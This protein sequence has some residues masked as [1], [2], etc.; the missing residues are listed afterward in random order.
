[1]LPTDPKILGVALVGGMIPSLIWLFFWLGEESTHPEPK[2]AITTIFILGMISVLVVLPIQRTIQ[3]LVANNNLELVLW[4][5]AEELIKFLAVVLILVKADTIDEPTD[6]PIY[7]ITVA[8]GFAALENIFFLL[9]PLSLGHTTA[10]L[11]NGQLRFLGSTLLHSIASAIIGISLGLSFYRKKIWKKIYLVIGIIIAI[12]LHS[13][14]NFF[15]IRNN[16]SD[17]MKVLAFLWVATI[18]VMLM[19]EKLRR[20]K[21]VTS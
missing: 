3:N 7:L 14:F 11:I 2:G 19:F 10:G 4:A 8:L 6:W 18:V 20:M 16:G 5:T 21:Q 9:K 17:F 13:A 1:M 12:S 15:I